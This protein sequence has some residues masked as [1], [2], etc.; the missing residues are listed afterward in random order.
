MDDKRPSSQTRNQHFLVL[1]AWRGICACLVA[2]FHFSSTSHLQ[3][4]PL[5]RNAYLFVDFFFVLSG[6]VIFAS[7]EEKLQRGF[8][9]GRFLVLRFGRLYPLHLALFIAFVGADLLKLLPLFG[10][11]ST[12]PPFTAPGETPPYIVTNLLLIQ[13]LGVQH[14][15]SWNDPSWSISVEFYTYVVFGIAVVLLK[16]RIRWLILALLLLSPLFLAVFSSQYM[17]TTFQYGFIRCLFG[18]SAGALCWHVFQ[19]YQSAAAVRGSPRLWDA[20]EIAMLIAVAWFVTV[21]GSSALTLLAPLL[22]SATILVFSMERGLISRLLQT[23]VFL[24]LGVLS[25]SLYMDHMFIRR[26]LF[27]SGAMVVERLFHVSLITRVSGGELIGTSPWQGDLLMLAYLGVLVALA[28]ATYH[29]I[30]DPCRNW[31]KSLVSAPRR[32]S[33]QAPVRLTPASARAATGFASARPVPPGTPAAPPS[34]GSTA[35]PR[36]S[37]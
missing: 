6:F 14:R 19:R 20:A 37:P 21:A 2:L 26:K 30:E 15:L 22:F 16:N 4:L 32:R 11:Y 33:A 31:F 17:N 27:V 34:L 3:N 8:G 9:F 1:D 10:G 7:Y 24:L 5:L 36:S 35:A 18:F 28:Y 13:S 29:W 23:R 25:Y 12:Y